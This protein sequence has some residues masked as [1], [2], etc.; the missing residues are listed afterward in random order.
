[1][2][3]TMNAAAVNVSIRAPSAARQLRRTRNV[4]RVVRVRLSELPSKVMVFFF[5]FLQSRVGE[6]GDEKKKKNKKSPRDRDGS[7]R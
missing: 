4:A 3:A 7:E 6:E 5:F 2:A 1:M